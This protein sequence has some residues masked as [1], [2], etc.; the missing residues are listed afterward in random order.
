MLLSG[1]ECLPEEVLEAADCFLFNSEPI[2]GFL[3][4][5]LYLLRLR[6]LFQ[7]LLFLT[8]AG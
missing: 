3:E 1:D 6:I 5:V 4:Q 7:P 8:E 2:A